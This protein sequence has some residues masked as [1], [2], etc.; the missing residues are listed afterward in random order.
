MRQWI[1]GVSL[2][3]LLALQLLSA[4][5]CLPERGHGVFLGVASDRG[6][7]PLRGAHSNTVGR[8]GMHARFGVL[9]GGSDEEA[10]LGP[11]ASDAGVEY[12]EPM[13]PEQIELMKL[14]NSLPPR[15]LRTLDGLADGWEMV[16]ETAVRST[17]PPAPG[18]PRSHNSGRDSRGATGQDPA[19]RNPASVRVSQGVVRDER[20]DV[21]MEM[22]EVWEDDEP[23]GVRV[24]T[25][26]AAATRLSPAA[27]LPSCPSPL[28]AFLTPRTPTLLDWRYASR[29][30]TKM[31]TQGP[32]RLNHRVLL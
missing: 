22:E 11:P 19:G 16:N 17:L 32:C 9:R 20:G 21:G 7:F 8:S 12:N 31:S 29:P 4:R 18:W 25:V 27:L 14:S 6:D 26:S 3:L 30:G 24:T 1:G 13:T 15:V 2:R 23:V 28:L 5:P 10:E